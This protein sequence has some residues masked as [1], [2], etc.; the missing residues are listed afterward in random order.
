VSY[1]DGGW[2]H[3]SEPNE[4]NLEQGKRGNRIQSLDS[5]FLS[6]EERG[7]IVPKTLEAAL[8]AA[9]TYFLTTQPAPGDPRESM[10]Q[11]TI[12][13]LG[14]IGDKLQQGKSHGMVDRR[15][16]IIPPT[17]AGETTG[18]GLHTMKHHNH[19]GLGNLG[20]QTAIH[21]TETQGTS[22]RRHG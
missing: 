19:A 22:S 15:I 21:G 16:D 13:G 6:V 2:Y 20:R 7:N 12:K 10:H 18:P 5:S 1:I 8:V 9:Q 14:L 11:A 17:R 4:G 3:R